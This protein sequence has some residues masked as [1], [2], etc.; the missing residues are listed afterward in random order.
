MR[1]W[2]GAVGAAL[3]L[4]WG[5]FPLASTA[6]A[7][8]PDLIVRSADVVDVER[9]VIHADRDVH[10]RDGV[11]QRIAPSSDEPAPDAARVVEADGLFLMP[12]LIDAHVHTIE[13]DV[14]GPL[15]VA[16]GVVF[17][18]DMGGPT[19]DILETRRR[20]NA[21]EVLAPEMMCTGAII[22]G[23]PPFWPFSIPCATP[24]EGRAAVRDLAARGV[25]QIKVYN[26]LRREVYEAICEEAHAAGLRPVGHIPEA[27]T[28]DQAIAAGQ[29][30]NEHLISFEHALLHAMEEAPD[31]PDAG[32]FTDMGAWAMI[33]RV[34]HTR[35]SAELERIAASGMV[36]C[37][38]LV[39][40][41]GISSIA[42][43][44]R[45]DH[46]QM[47]FIPPAIRAFWTSPRY[48]GFARFALTALPNMIEVVGLLHEAG[49]P[50][51]VGT[52]LANPYV[53]PGYSVHEE[54]E[55]FQQAG[56]TPAEALRDATID[57][58]R[59]LEVD[60][61]FGSVAP[62]RTASLVLLRDNPLED[63]RNAQSIETVILRGRVLDRA[64]LDEM[65]EEAAAS[66]AAAPAEDE[67]E[68]DLH[69]EIP[70]EL[71]ASGTF[72]QKF[73]D[74][75]AGSEQFAIARTQDGYVLRAVARSAGGPQPS[76]EATVYADEQ[77]NIQRV[78]YENENALAATY[79]VDG[80]RFVAE[81]A[82]GDERLE[83]VTLDLPERR[84]IY[85]PLTSVDFFVLN[86][87]G[88]EVGES[89]ALTSVSVAQQ[90]WR[91]QVA[92]LTITREP[93]QPPPAE[94]GEEAPRRAYSGVLETPMGAVQLQMVTTAEGVPVTSRISMPFGEFT[95]T[96][97]RD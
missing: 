20:F 5:A 43:E 74:F 54:L 49:A 56:L 41:K 84:A 91:S 3:A 27:V 59:A 34:D 2:T 39:V 6:A 86:S 53:F 12:G 70:G 13:P 50:L 22:D 23:D 36:Q 29:R 16:H 88:L 47:R 80:E 94:E 28:I 87:L 35:L 83:P 71:L 77:F 73:G 25:D 30:T 64:R 89:I 46:P 1:G 24:E 37:P 51:I 26:N 79:T 63:I 21:G 57:S 45:D 8:P 18:R 68:R 81:A 61:R 15:M 40:M 93:D 75:D 72:R 78:E 69:F 32:P 95:S 31:L 60:H 67:A 38:T 90:G 9:G 7:E 58:A 4:V 42:G 17:V 44:S 92:P 11:I 65:L 33:D 62:G 14:S 96:R 76:F 52:D 55:M 97:E 48:E 19:D 82:Q 10:I 85:P 66:V